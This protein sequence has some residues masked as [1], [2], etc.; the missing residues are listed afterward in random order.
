MAYYV[1]GDP[2]PLAIVRNYEE[3]RRTAQA[4]P[5]GRFYKVS[6]LKAYFIGKKINSVRKHSR[7]ESK[8][9]STLVNTK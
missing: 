4:L 8:N 7:T 3:A 6:W 2:C 1:V 9:I 5:E